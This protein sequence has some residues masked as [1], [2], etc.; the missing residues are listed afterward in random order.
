MRIAQEETFG[1]VAPIMTFDTVDEAIG[2]ANATEFG[3]TATVFTN[4]LKIAWTMA[5]ALGTARC[6]STR[7]RTTGTRWRRSAARRSPARAASCRAT[8]STR[9]RRRSRSPGSSARSRV[10]RATGAGETTC[11]AVSAVA[12]LV[13]PVVVDAEVVRDL[14]QHRH[15]DLLGQLDRVVPEVGDQRRAV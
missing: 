8:S 12:E 15:A 9:C 7:R 6:T 5:E 4:D 11:R 10:R 13:Q 1:P 14:V 2:I 3:L